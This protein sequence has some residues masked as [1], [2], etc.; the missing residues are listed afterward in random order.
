MESV[1]TLIRKKKPMTKK[2]SKNWW[3]AIW[4]G[5]VTEQTAKHHK[6]MGK[7]LWLYL[8]FIVHANRNTGTLF[9]KTST[10][11]SDMGISIR[12]IQ[13]WL[14]ILRKNGYITTEFTGRA[15]VISITKWKPISRSKNTNH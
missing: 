13:H 15:L 6:A 7:A 14:I 5:L 11:A 9:R 12:T 1:G 10:I 3:G 8:Y 2:S 4:V